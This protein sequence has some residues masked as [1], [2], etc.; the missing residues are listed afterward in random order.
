M[1]QGPK[2]VKSAQPATRWQDALISG[3]GST[4][5]M[6][7]GEPF[8]EKIVLNH[9]KLWVIAVDA[10]RDVADM[11]EAYM[12]ARRLAADL[13]FDDAEKLIRKHFN[14]QNSRS[15]GSEQLVNGR[16]PVD[17]VHPG[18]HLLLSIPKVAG[19]T[20]YSREMILDTGECVVAWED[21][22]GVWER[23]AF[24]S[25]PDD[26]IIIR[27]RC[28]GSSGID[29]DVRLAE[30]EG[31]LSG[32]IAGLEIEH[33]NEEASFVSTYAR[34]AGEREPA[35][36]HAL[37]RVVC[38]GGSSEASGGDGMAIR[39]AH[40]VLLI[41]RLEY[42]KCVSTRDP[43]ALRD[44]LGLLE[45]DY[46]SL[47]RR[48][49]AVHG[50]MFRR[51]RLRLGHESETEI[52]S[53]EIL[54]RTQETGPDAGLLEM[55]HAVG[56]YT[57]ICSSGHLPPTLM[58]IWGDDWNAPWDGR[59]TF[60]SN[61]NLAV[62]AGSQGDLPE[63]M[64]G[65]FQFIEHIARD[66]DRNAQRLYGCRGYVSELTQ[67]YRDGL[68]MFGFY[69]WTGGAGWLCNYFYDHYLY[70][71][72]IV[73]LKNRVIPLLKQV[74]QF[75]ED[76]LEGSEDEGGK[77][78]FYPSISPENT[79]SRV[80][81]GEP[82]DIVPNATSEIAICRQVLNNLIDGCRE[83]KIEEKS[84]SRWEEMLEKL[85]AYCIN[86]DGAISE[87]SYPGIADN[88]NHRH[89]SHLYGVYPALEIDPIQS[90]FLADAAAVAIKKRLEAGRGHKSAH[91]LMHL[92]LFAARLWDSALLWTMF[93]EFARSGYLFTSMI[94]SH[95]P[96]Q[97]IYNLDAT[98]SIPAV[99]MEMLVQSKPGFLY[100]LPALPA[101]KLPVGTIE[102]VLARGQIRVIS[103]SWNM[104]VGMLSVSLLSGTT[105][106]IVLRGP[107]PYK[108]ILVTG[109]THGTI[110]SEKAN[111]FCRVKLIGNQPL[112]LRMQFDR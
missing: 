63:A 90:D 79:P 44:A 73:F 70:T 1:I 21:S 72:N 110:E 95:N 25:R 60:D 22:R 106:S 38:E 98:L 49:A 8:C 42:L 69:P 101:E 109:G 93:T 43:E 57:L 23:R 76:F 108:K 84:L 77:Y 20:N 55:L 36:Y 34:L 46:E 14:E 75:Y 82:S 4:G 78:V 102:G 41:I 5:I 61:L 45:A 111:M 92:S 52:T 100:L 28:T 15:Y 50:E 105:Q 11:R 9:E 66:W 74:A 17:R 26:A 107:R 12:Q 16:L 88:Y 97:D 68:T 86:A 91:G 103:L 30:A 99:L 40:E 62:S 80:P 18:L 81:R 104:E 7:M 96:G 47:L 37:M 19:V 85:P 2:R 3:N 87:W 53:E 10:K 89:N 39:G 35:G 71:G 112:H 27:L 32:D 6:V 33:R 54:K 56:R 24:V 29:C 67:G 94:T 64:E 59:Y 48:H 31:K 51:V 13:R 83:L 65:Y 58:G